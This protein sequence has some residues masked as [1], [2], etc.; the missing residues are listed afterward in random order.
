MS[1]SRTVGWSID[2]VQAGT[3]AVQ[4]IRSNTAIACFTVLV[5][6]LLCTST[7]FSPDLDT[8]NLAAFGSRL[9][10]ATSLSQIPS[11]FNSNWQ[12][13]FSITTTVRYSR[14]QNL[15]FELGAKRTTLSNLGGREEGEGRREGRRKGVRG[16]EGEEGAE[17]VEGRRGGGRGEVEGEQ[18]VR[19]KKGGRRKRGRGG[20]G[21][22]E[23]GGG[24][25]SDRTSK[26][27][28]TLT[29]HRE[30]I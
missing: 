15:N 8:A 2:C 13:S 19:G 6:L 7:Q 25:G 14:S 28:R 29:R 10:K 20:R 22:R 26:R 21:K 16:E 4:A 5:S 30:A 3:R 18:G 9:S 23:A 11:F 17:G 27:I 12:L 24:G 1:S